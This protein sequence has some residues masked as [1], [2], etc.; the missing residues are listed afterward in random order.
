[1]RSL[2]LAIL[3]IIG[4]VGLQSAAIAQTSPPPAE[5]TPPDAGEPPPSPPAGQQPPAVNQPPP[6]G[7]Q[8]PPPGY[9]QQ[10]PPGYYQQPPPGY[11][12]QP[13]P[14][15]QPPPPGYYQQPPP[16]Y[17]QPP[18]GYYQQ[19]PPGTYQPQAPAAPPPPP[20]TRGFLA[21]PYLGVQSQAGDTGRPYRAGF[22]LGALLGGRINPAF[23]VNGELRIDTLNFANVPAGQH[24]EASEV[25]L[26]FSPLFHAPFPAGEFVVG[27]KLGLF[28]QNAT[29]RDDNSV[30][31]TRGRA[32]GLTA[33][34]NA[35]VFFIVSRVMS[36]GG[37]LS[38]TIRD[39]AEVC[40][41]DA[42]G[43]ETCVSADYAA[44]KVFGF[45]AAALF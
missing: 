14:G 28:G 21:L 30:T 35:G 15:Y 24:W 25:D 37:M 44:E 27:P 9:Y 7:Y 13:P 6:P 16:G 20:R 31:T 39:P 43:L 3:S 17:Q 26:A 40:A 36:L 33:G 4:V 34:V 5:P 11:Y 2:R 18:P 1:M 41:T 29:L 45:H 12:Q 22:M 42:S 32:S 8:Q 19:P 38:F 23:S 10:P